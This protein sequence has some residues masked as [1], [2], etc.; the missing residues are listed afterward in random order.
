M[1]TSKAIKKL[2]KG[3]IKVLADSGTARDNISR[4]ARNSG[5]AVT[6]EE[7]PEG[8]FRILLEK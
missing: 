8:N 2:N 4:L 1:L 3:T 6:V 5:W 7:K